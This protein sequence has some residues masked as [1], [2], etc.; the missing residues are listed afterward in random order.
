MKKGGKRYNKELIYVV[1]VLKFR[2]TFICQNKLVELDW[3]C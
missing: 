3:S 1:D 2:N